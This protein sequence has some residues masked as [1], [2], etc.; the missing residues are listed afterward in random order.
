MVGLDYLTK[1]KIVR[2]NGKNQAGVQGMDTQTGMLASQVL[3][4]NRNVDGWELD[5][6]VG[7]ADRA[8]I[9]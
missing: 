7:K 1:M 9:P 8:G 3:G 2:G 6:E 5:Q 4:R